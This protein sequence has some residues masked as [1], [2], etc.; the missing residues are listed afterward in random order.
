[1]CLDS[2]RPVRLC[3][4]FETMCSFCPQMSKTTKQYWKQLESFI[5]DWNQRIQKH[6]SW[7]TKRSIYK[8]IIYKHDGIVEICFPILG[9]NRDRDKVEWK[10]AEIYGGAVRT[11]A[12][13]SEHF[14]G[15]ALKLLSHYT[16]GI[17][18][19]ADSWLLIQVDMAPPLIRQEKKPQSYHRPPWDHFSPSIT[20][21]KSQSPA[22]SL[23][24]LFGLRNLGSLFIDLRCQ[25]VFHMS[26]IS[27]L[28]LHH[29]KKRQEC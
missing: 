27:N 22:F 1:M 29:C 20:Q 15:Q 21:D 7:L 16:D 5:L 14:R 11:T 26:H 19:M 10:S 24:S 23:F 17:N 3:L 2:L 12:S 8:C 9:R 13:Y 4:Q 28:V 6:W 25:V 18:H